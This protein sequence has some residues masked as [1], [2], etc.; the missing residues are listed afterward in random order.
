MRFE[1]DKNVAPKG[2]TGLLLSEVIEEDDVFG[3]LEIDEDA[4]GAKPFSSEHEELLMIEEDIIGIVT[5]KSL[6]DISMIG[7]SGTSNAD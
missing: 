6:R 7:T 5:K 3:S 1:G 2:N 4:L